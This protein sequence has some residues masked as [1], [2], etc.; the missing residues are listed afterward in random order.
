MTT[1]RQRV[2]S[3]DFT[4]IPTLCET[5][6]AVLDALS[7]EFQLALAELSESE[8]LADMPAPKLLE[9]LKE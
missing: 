2:S 5:Y 8:E 4:D 7:A 1:R 9:D 3:P 6:V